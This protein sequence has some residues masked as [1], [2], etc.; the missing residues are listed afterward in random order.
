VLDSYTA[1]RSRRKSGADIVKDEMEDFRALDDLGKRLNCTIAILHH[2]SHGN[3]AKSWSERAGGTFGVGM[4]VEGLIFIDK[5]TE[6]GINAPE[7]LVRVEARHIGSSAR[8]LRF[9]VETHDYEHVAE[10]AAAEHWPTLVDLKK[11]FPEQPFTPKDL[12]L[13]LGL[14]RATS[15]RII[16]RLM[17]AG[18]IRKVSYGSYLLA[19]AV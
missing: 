18:V 17:S 6:L 3:A 1:L 15:T 13:E 2:I 8:I 7:R 9:R 12:L 16:T 4:A 19:E 11:H 5:F 10:G 14:S